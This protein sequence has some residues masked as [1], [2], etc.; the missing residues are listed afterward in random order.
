MRSSAFMADG[1]RPVSATKAELRGKRF[2]HYLVRVSIHPEEQVCRELPQ[3]SLWRSASAPPCRRGRKRSLRR[4]QS[5]NSVLTQIRRFTFIR[6]RAA[7]LDDESVPGWS[8][9]QE[10]R[11]TSRLTASHEL[12][13]KPT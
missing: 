1:H 5:W 2:T 10:P 6:T 8:W 3:C 9:C 12:F 7:N 11:C 13:L 4:F